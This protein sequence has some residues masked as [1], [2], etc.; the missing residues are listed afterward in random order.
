MTMRNSPGLSIGRRGFVA[1]ASALGMLSAARGAH[2]QS[3]PRRGGVLRVAYN[4]EQANLN[5]ALIASNAVYLV[6]SK[7]IEPLA[8]MDGL[9]G[10]VRPLLATAWEGTPDGRTITF[11]LRQGVKF[12]NGRELKAEDVQYSLNR[13]LDPKTASPGRS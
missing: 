4:T 10:G 12:H 5:P 7:V 1:G 2:A 8:E 13:V 6:A 9:A 3:A 11:R